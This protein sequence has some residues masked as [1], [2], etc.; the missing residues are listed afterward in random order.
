MSRA[1]R[2]QDALDEYLWGYTHGLTGESFPGCLQRA[3]LPYDEVRQISKNVED[4]AWQI[5]GETQQ[6]QNA[7]LDAIDALHQPDTDARCA[8]DWQPWPCQTHLLIYPEQPT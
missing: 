8:H 7:L 2:F 1:G 6:R 5:I 3:G 4:L